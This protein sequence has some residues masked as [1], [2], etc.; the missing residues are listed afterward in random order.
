MKKLKR[1]AAGLLL[2][3][4]MCVQALPMTAWAVDLPASDVVV[5]DSD[6]IVSDTAPVLVEA[7][8][9]VPVEVQCDTSQTDYFTFEDNGDGNY[10]VTGTTEAFREL[11]N[12]SL[13]LAEDVKFIGEAAF[14]NCTNLKSVD[15]ENEEMV[16]YK[17]AFHGCSRLKAVAFEKIVDML[18]YAFMGCEKLTTVNLT[19]TK[20]GR[21]GSEAF[22]GCS[23]LE[24]VTISITDKNCEAAQLDG[25]GQHI[26]GEKDSFVGTAFILTFQLNMNK[27]NMMTISSGFYD[28]N[29]IREVRFE[30]DGEVGIGNMA[31]RDNTMLRN[32]DFSHVVVVADDAFEG[33]TQLSEIQLKNKNLRYIGDAAF[34]GC[35]SANDIQIALNDKLEIGEYAFGRRQKSEGNVK[36][37]SMTIYTNNEDAYVLPDDFEREDRLLNTFEVVGNG[38]LYYS[39]G[40]FSYCENLTKVNVGNALGFGREAFV[41]CYKLKSLDLTSAHLFDNEAFKNCDEL[42]SLKLGV[43]DDSQWYEGAFDDIMTATSDEDGNKISSTLELYMNNTERP[44][45][46]GEKGIKCSANVEFTSMYNL[47]TVKT[48]GDGELRLNGGQFSN[49]DELESFDFSNV[50]KI[51]RNALSNTGLKEVKITRKDVLY[52]DRAFGSCDDLTLYGYTDSTTEKYANDN[53]IPFVALDGGKTTTATS[54]TGQGSSTT[55]T[56]VTT[57]GNS[58]TILLGDITLDGRVDISDAVLLNK[59]TAGSVMLNEQAKDNAECYADGNIDANDSTALL[60]FLVHTIASLPVR[61]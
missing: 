8:T 6:T 25:I 61:E 34:L 35:T 7:T 3:G 53:N 42:E 59:A 27:S 29:R 37:Y 52:G 17:D 13:T 30:G 57:Q 43:Y 31:F 49:C 48:Y 19:N 21:V 50:T 36:P 23:S 41:N 26:F 22:S 18:D 38:E 40:N 46:L 47:T 45:E 2:A 54:T 10:T 44:F 51:G 60:Q 20:L 56:T 39:D 12:V 4:V 16:L 11:E 14:A 1:T 15:F 58:G 33:C 55:T 5:T 32:F 24:D 9:N 28:S